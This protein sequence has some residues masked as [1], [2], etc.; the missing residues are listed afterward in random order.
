MPADSLFPDEVIV[1]ESSQQ[2]Q[3]NRKKRRA[4][5]EKGAQGLVKGVETEDGSRLALDVAPVAA[6]EARFAGLRIDL[7]GDGSDSQSFL[8]CLADGFQSVGRVSGLLR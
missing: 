3:P 4:E 1:G 6:N 2:E 5:V 8:A 7:D